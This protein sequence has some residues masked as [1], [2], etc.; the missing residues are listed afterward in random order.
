MSGKQAPC[1]EW[2]K[3]RHLYSFHTWEHRT[4]AGREGEEPV[5]C[6]T[7]GTRWDEWEARVDRHFD[8]YMEAYA[9]LP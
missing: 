6:T 3:G 9:D 8:L 7:C 2:A 4:V 1:T 5:Q